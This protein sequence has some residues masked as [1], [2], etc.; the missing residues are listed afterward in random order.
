MV[1][2]GEYD[3]GFETGEDAAALGACAY[4]VE[5]GEAPSRPPKYPLSATALGFNPNGEYDAGLEVAED[6]AWVDT[7]GEETVDTT[8][9]PLRFPR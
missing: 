6:A 4:E 5:A 7:T 1:P 9:A 2:N 8:E 3:A